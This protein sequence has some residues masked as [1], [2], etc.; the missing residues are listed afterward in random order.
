MLCEY[1][2]LR[3]EADS[4]WA[5]RLNHYNTLLLP[6]VWIFDI[7]QI[8]FVEQLDSIPKQLTAGWS[9]ACVTNYLHWQ[10]QSERICSRQE[11]CL[12]NIHQIQT[13]S[14]LVPCL[15]AVSIRLETREKNWFIHNGK[16]QTT[17]QACENIL[18]PK[19]GMNGQTCFRS[20]VIRSSCP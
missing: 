12:E 8:L 19:K 13:H 5:S 20:A 11:C 15:L 3:F 18:G 6:E 17:I 1:M 10:L 16:L 4:C 2:Q 9:C 14:Q 7:N